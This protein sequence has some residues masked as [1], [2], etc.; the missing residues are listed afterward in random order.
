M[1]CS[2]IRSALLAC[3]TLGC[4]QSSPSGPP[5]FPGPTLAAGEICDATNTS[6]LNLTFD[7]PS[8]VLATTATASG[9]IRPVRV[10][11]EPDLCSPT[12]LVLSMGDSSVASAP[13]GAILDLR[14]PTFDFT[15]S[16]ATTKASATVLT[17]RLTRASDGASV[18]ATLPIKVLDD[19][20]P[21]KC[22]VGMASQVMDASHTTLAGP[23]GVASLSV[24][25]GAYAR[26][27]WLAI[28]TFTATLACGA[29]LS[30]AAPGNLMAIGPAVSFTA[31]APIVQTESLRREIDFAIPVNPAAIPAAGRM[32]HLEVLYQGPTTS[33]PRVIPVA[34]PRIEQVAKTQDYVLRFSSPW[35]GTYQAAFATDAGAEHHTRHLTHRA[36]VGFSMGGGGAAS[37]GMRHHDQFDAI[38]PMGGPSDWNWLLWYVEKYALGGF[39]PSGQPNCPT[40]GP[41]EYPLP[42]TYA[43][44]MDWN[45]WW[46][47][48]G[49][50][51]GGRFSRREWIQIFEDLA[52]MSGNPNGQNAD[53]T[54]SFFAAGPKATDP[55]VKGSAP[56]LPSGI[57]CR[58][59]VSPINGDPN[60][61]QQQAWEQ[62]C[63][64]SRCD[65]KNTWIAPSNYFDDEY[66]PDGTQQVIS[67]CDGNNNGQSPYEDTWAPPVPGMEIPVDLALAVDLNRDGVRQVNEP[68]IR[69]GH[70]PWDDTG[71]DGLFDAQEPG[72][73][74]IANPDPDQDDY[75]FQINPGGTE[76]DHHY[77]LGESFQDVG[78]DGV[79]N[80]PQLSQGGYDYGEADG[81]FT[82][83]DGLARFYHS[84]AHSILH[85]WVTDVPGGPMTDE[86]LLRF[87]VWSDGGVRDLFNFAAVANHMEGAIASRKGPNGLP[88]R[89]TAF[90][91]GFTALP[92][93]DPTQ[94]ENFS[95]DATRWADVVDMPSI[96]YGTVDA[97]PTQIMEGDGQHVGTGTQALYRLEA[98]L[99][100]VSQKWPDADRTL[101]EPTN[102]NPESS[103]MNV[104]GTACE[105]LGKCE[106][107]FTGPVTKR[108]GPIAIQLPPGYALA[109]NVQR[110][111]RYP[112]VFV[113]HGYGQSPTDLEAIA[114]VSTNF[115]NDERHSAATR[116]PKFIIVYVDGRCRISASGQP[117]C[118]Q[119]TFYLDSDRANYLDPSHP[120]IAQIDTWFDEV[121]SYVDQNYRT[122]GPNDIQVSE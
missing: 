36:V 7:P 121:V 107:L 39:C 76:N 58:V 75:E 94:P 103:T 17:A 93:Q 122:M 61:A 32:R 52:L 62:A 108:T 4:S 79:K 114:L 113:L 13:T 65:P 41:S 99:Y 38:A 50:G 60:N 59:T 63:T 101:T 96:R 68:V 83:A 48:A 85:Q 27:D 19:T 64:A 34:S 112:V 30:K 115:M 56:G 66:N 49:N 78:L 25:P 16:A 40:F 80:T 10:T 67:F 51:N 22:G 8:L 37:F 77:E 73:D 89:S 18:Q 104:L 11:F 110:N 92:G 53:P 74:P 106:T 9:H 86:E 87:N 119:G 42:E 3:F 88:L 69:E 118:I 57:D 31:G 120:K 54:L 97:T 2:F 5:P 98:S 72:Y 28:P 29:D 70:E 33:T 45:H 82:M 24:P 81:K 43:H 44:T 100:F 55:W 21:T 117:E 23:G 35:F 46:Y 47:E 116:L 6:N 14:H 109:E 1:K 105:L 26:T 12:A 91:N 90:Y 111:V 84:D 15:V 102:T 20:M 71:V 95:P